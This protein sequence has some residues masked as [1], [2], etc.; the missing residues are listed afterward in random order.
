MQIN[1]ELDLHARRACMYTRITRTASLDPF[2]SFSASHF[3]QSPNYWSGVSTGFILSRR[4]KILPSD[5]LP[6]PTKRALV[7]SYL[8]AG[9][10]SH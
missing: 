6:T 3:S 1:G 10:L 2:A 8:S 4:S 5:G 9:E 7:I